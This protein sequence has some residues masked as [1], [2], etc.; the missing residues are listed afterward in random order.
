[1]GPVNVAVLACVLMTSTRKIVN[2]LRKEV[3]LR[4]N[5]GYAYAG[6][7]LEKFIRLGNYVLSRLPQGSEKPEGKTS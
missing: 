2:F 6:M 1:V 5:P 3:H 4:E 7:C